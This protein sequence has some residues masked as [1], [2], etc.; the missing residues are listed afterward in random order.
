MRPCPVCH[1]AP[2]RPLIRYAPG[3]RPTLTPAQQV[4]EQVSAAAAG[5]DA[6]T[7]ARLVD[8]DVVLDYTARRNHV[9]IRPRRPGEP[10]DG[11]AEPLDAAAEPPGPDHEPP[12]GALPVDPDTIPTL[13]E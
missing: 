9:L 4:A 6:D 11:T 7:I 12:S 8:F 2:P 10:L 5:G 1:P 13:A 3:V